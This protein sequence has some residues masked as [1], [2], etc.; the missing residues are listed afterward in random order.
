MCFKNT[1]AEHSTR[2]IIFVFRGATHRVNQHDWP[3]VKWGYPN[4]WMV[5]FMENPTKM[6][7]LGVALF[8]GNHLM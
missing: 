4:S 7:D 1:F 5:Y 2:T 3:T 6:D 8:L